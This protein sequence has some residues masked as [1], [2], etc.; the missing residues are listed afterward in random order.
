MDAA[1]RSRFTVPI[2]TLPVTARE[3]ADRAVYVS[4]ESGAFQIHSWDR[5]G[6]TRTRITDEPGGA[7]LC[8]ISPDGEAIWSFSDP[9]GAES[10]HWNITPFPQARVEATRRVLD[11]ELG[12]PVG[13]AI[14][15][16]RAVLGIACDAGVTVWVVDDPQGAQQVR[17]LCFDPL[18]ATV[19]AMDA[20]EELVAISRADEGSSLLR[21]RVT[22]LRVSDGGE[23]ARIWDG[24][25]HGLEVSGFA[26]MTGD[27]RLL[28]T[29]ERGGFRRPFIWDVA[30]DERIEPDIGLDGDLWA[31]WYPDGTALLIARSAR[32]RVRLYRYEIEPGIL[33]PL[34]SR[35]GWVGTGAVRPDGAIEYLWCDAAHPPQHRILHP[36]GTDDLASPP[37]GDAAPSRPVMDAFVPVEDRPGES[38]HLLYAIPDDERRPYPTVFMIHG[39][40]YAADEDFYSP[41]R[42][43]W[44]DAGFA[45]VHVNYRGSTGYGR[46]WRDA[47]LGDP[48][49]RAASDIA[50]ARAW[51]VET[52]LAHA[53][54]C[55]VQGWSW[56][57]YLSL[58]S[59][60]LHPGDWSACIAGAPIADYVRAYD[61]QLDALR[62]FDRELFDGTPSD[63]PDLY[64]ASSPANYVA[65]I[66]CP[67]L[68]LYGRHD[69]RTPAGQIVAFT[70]RLTEY[71]KPYQVYEFDAG[72]GS[73]DIAETIRQVETE[74][75]F[76]LRQLPPTYDIGS[77]PPV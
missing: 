54:K 74:I 38:L 16:R 5:G 32:G 61:E 37:P 15:N 12:M 30:A 64:A 44:L 14:G 19:H 13:H 40:P 21:P 72:H 55:V 73:F 46:E 48:G 59:A 17:R 39:G 10:G 33:S 9:V 52:G 71:G 69:P 7:Y 8:A 36:D 11:V 58:L 76:A 31:R 6:D 49:R 35:T 41:T 43:A 24:P 70:N 53:S 75:R 4:N 34:A 2:I 51:A 50:R 28:M 57:G 1:A 18:M 66:D 22:V 29:H 45:V 77:D 42:A 23:V 63:K 68:I 3:C 56:G 26:P 20:A 65:D 27:I 62:A 67:V 25:D 60:G 47:I